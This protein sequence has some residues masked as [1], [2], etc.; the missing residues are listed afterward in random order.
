M[1]TSR[2]Q[3]G[4]IATLAAGLGFTVSSSPAIGYPAGATV[5]LGVNP[6]VSQ[7]GS[8]N[9]P[10]ASS[11]SAELITAPSDQDLIITDL[12]LDGAANSQSCVEQ[13]RV[14]LTLPGST[15]ASISVSPK[16]RHYVGHS[17]TADNNFD[18]AQHLQLRSGIRI[19]AG[20][21][22]QLEA[23]P[24]HYSGC[25]TSRTAELIWTVSGYYAQP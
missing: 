9:I 4:L 16:F 7:G 11:T 6:V 12:V 15:L 24:Y 17:Y 25:G 10:Y 22:A 8:M 13:W 5:S 3:L 18:G 14:D 23:S 19:P 21:T 2:F 1:Q 20:A